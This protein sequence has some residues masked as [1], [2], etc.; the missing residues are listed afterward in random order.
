MAKVKLGTAKT[1]G[2]Y[3][4]NV[5]KEYTEIHEGKMPHTVL[6]ILSESPVIIGL[7]LNPLTISDKLLKIRSDLAVDDYGYS[8][9]LPTLLKDFMAGDLV[10]KVQGKFRITPLGLKFLKENVIPTI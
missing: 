4:I 6:C 7:G 2:F 10:E 9:T 8:T 3:S 5:E 1:H